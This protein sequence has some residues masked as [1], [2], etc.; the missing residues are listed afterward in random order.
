MFGLWKLSCT[1]P[2]WAARLIGIHQRAEHDCVAQEADCI[3]RAIDVYAQREYLAGEDKFGAQM[4]SAFRS[5]VPSFPTG[6]PERTE[7]A[8]LAPFTIVAHSL[9]RRLPASLAHTRC[10]SWRIVLHS[11]T[12]RLRRLPT[13]GPCTSFVLVLRLCAPCLSLFHP[14]ESFL[15]LQLP[16]M[17]LSLCICTSQFLS[18]LLHK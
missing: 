1:T 5:L 17:I 13:S 6:A 2:R 4:S 16:D 8:A 18:D 3:H 7:L 14:S 9:S 10:A 11:P 12:S 15:Q